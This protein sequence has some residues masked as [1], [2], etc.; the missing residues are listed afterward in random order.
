MDISIN[1]DN[2]RLNVRAAALIIHNNKLL[3]H[4]NDNED[5]YAILG[6][7]IQIGENSQETLKREILE[8]MGKEIEIKG[9][10]ATIENFFTFNG[11]NNHEYMF[12]YN[13]D[14]KDENDKKILDMINNV[15][16][17][18][19][20]HYEWIDLDKIDSYN[21]LPKIMKDV[22]KSNV[23]PVH[24]INDDLNSFYN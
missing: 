8:E 4:K 17:N 5:F 1:V 24:K 20:L 2:Y 11:K 21:I 14:F 9:Y 18:D 16:G 15:E 13:A 3:V 10:A 19:Y 22:L 12:V 6:G 23:F 7:R